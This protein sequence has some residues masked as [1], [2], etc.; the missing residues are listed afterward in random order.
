MKDKVLNAFKKLSTINKIKFILAIVLTAAVVIS[1]P[2]LAWFTY[3]KQMATMAKIDSPAKLSLLS[4]AGED[5]IRFKMS[6]IDVTQG[7][8]ESFVFCVE[9][10]DIS[11]Y[12]LQLAHTTNIKFSY[13]IYQAIED[14][15]GEV[16]YTKE[17]GNDVRYKK[18]ATKLDLRAVNEENYKGRKIG[19]ATYDEP[20]YKL[21][22]ARQKFAE[23]LY[24]QTFTPITADGGT[25]DA[26]PEPRSFQNYYVLRVYWPE[27]IKN[28]KETDM[29]YLTAQVASGN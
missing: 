5:I 28:D 19:T 8:E 6:D 4:G 27:G 17:D 21:G 26:D 14:P 9:G 10:A 12:N 11:Q 7:T 29:I 23:P 16:K 15:E 25:Y 24:W 3:Q 13:E 18:A 2:V 22:D 20:S 1:V